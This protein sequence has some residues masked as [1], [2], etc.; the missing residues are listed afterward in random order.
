MATNKKRL[1][2]SLGADME[3]T[4]SKMAK[5]DRVPQ[6]TKAAELLKYAIE[7]EEDQALERL[8][9]ERDTEDAQFISHEN[10]WK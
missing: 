4:L 1:N 9:S 7:L 2:I 6:A 3:E 8:A 10:A 5:F